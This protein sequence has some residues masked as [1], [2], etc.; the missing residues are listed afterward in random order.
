MSIPV[1]MEISL[2]SELGYEVIARDAIASFAH[3]LGFSY[4]RI[5]DM[6]TA[7]SEACIN[8]IEHGNLLEPDL[9][10]DIICTYEHGQLLIEVHDHGLKH[11]KPDKTIRTI[12]EKLAGLGPMR[13]MGLMLIQALADESHFIDKPRG[14]NCLC[15]TWHRQGPIT[16]AQQSPVNINS[17]P[18]GLD[19]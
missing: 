1:Y 11:H 12:E 3:N 16:N 15:L 17:D 14:G 19:P 18:V 5:D 6:K 4:D 2:P 9:R 13:G 8:A 10:V 7:L